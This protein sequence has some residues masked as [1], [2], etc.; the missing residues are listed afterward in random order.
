[1]R[2]CDRCTADF[3]GTRCELQAGGHRGYHRAGVLRWEHE[4]EKMAQRCMRTRKGDRCLLGQGHD[5][6]HCFCVTWYAYGGEE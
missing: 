1:M 4:P 2:E 3:N 6:P 5:G